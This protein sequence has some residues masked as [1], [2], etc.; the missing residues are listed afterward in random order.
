MT[1]Q[2]SFAPYCTVR[3]PGGVLRYR[4]IGSG[5][6]LVFV[7][8][9]FVNGNLWREVAPALAGRFRCIVPDLPLGAHSPAM[10]PDADLSLPGLARLVADFLAAL[11]L[12]GVTLVGSDSGGGISQLVIAHHP[13]RIGRLVLTNCDAYEHFPPPLVLPFKWAAFIPGFIAALAMTLRYVP[14]AD[15]LLYA[16]VARRNP[17]RAV[18]Q[19]Y[20]APLARDSGVRRDLTKALRGVS[21]RYTLEAARAFPGFNKPVLIVW[22][23]DDFVFPRRDAERLCREFPDARLE[24]VAGARAFVAEDQPA[25]LT[26]LIDSF[27]REPVTV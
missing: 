4:E 26:A 24:W 19:G 27:I 3:L 12:E 8:G 6:P 13:E 9:A 20:F 25:R 7:H 2:P 14:A 23:T 11:D 22:G 16:L 10:S 1:E 17:G 21:G 18:L 5:P 15:R